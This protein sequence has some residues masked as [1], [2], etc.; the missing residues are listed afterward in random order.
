MA[1]H[2]KNYAEIGRVLGSP[3]QSVSRQVNLF[4]R[5]PKGQDSLRKQ[6][7][8]GRCDICGAK[9]KLRIKVKNVIVALCKPCNRELTKD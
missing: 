8:G 9:E 6:M 4:Y 2:G 7:M 3:R 1:E 5:T